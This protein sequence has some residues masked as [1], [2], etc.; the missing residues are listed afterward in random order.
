MKMLDKDTFNK[1]IEFSGSKGLVFIGN[2]ILLYR[3]DGRT[4]RYPHY[5]DLPGGGREGHESPFDTFKRE[6]KE[7]FGIDVTESD[8][9]FCSVHESISDPGMTGYF[10]V[11]KLGDALKKEV[12]PSEEVPEPMF[13]TLEEYLLQPDVIPKQVERI[14]A[15]LEHVN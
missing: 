10:L 2:Q 3:R 14:R 5:L 7:E 4:T 8:I 9:S 6:L 12:K 13:M 1:D 15:Y 11:A